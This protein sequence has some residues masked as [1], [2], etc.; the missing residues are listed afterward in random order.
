MIAQRPLRTPYTPSASEIAQHRADGHNPYRDW[1]KDCNEAFGRESAHR[2]THH[3][4]VWVPVISCDYNFLSAHG[5]FHRSE[6]EPL[7]GESHL[8][9]LVIYDSSSK[10]IFAH[11]VPQKGVRREW[12]RC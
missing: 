7:E 10:G 12:L 1:C 2:D 9:V 4:A 5:V 3:D 11:A 6:W 8:K